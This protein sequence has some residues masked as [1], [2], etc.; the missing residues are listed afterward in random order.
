MREFKNGAKHIRPGE[1]LVEMCE[2]CGVRKA[3]HEDGL[4]S[5]CHAESFV[6]F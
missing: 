6:K 5:K 4:C 1:K 3:T 2:N